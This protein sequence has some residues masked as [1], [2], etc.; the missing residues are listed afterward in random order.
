M[1]H[2]VV[3]VLYV[4]L[5]GIPSTSSTRS[6]VECMQTPRFIDRRCTTLA[7]AVEHTIG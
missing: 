6:S 2:S 1:K 7:H 4:L 3:S 5:G